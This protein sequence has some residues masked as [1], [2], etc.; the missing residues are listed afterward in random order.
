M[1]RSVNNLRVA[2]LT[3]PAIL[4]LAP[5]MFA[6]D[7]G[8]INSGETHIGLNI[9]VPSPTDT[10]WFEGNV[11][12]RVIVTAVTTSGSLDTTIYL[13]PPGGGP[14]E[15]DTYYTTG[16]YANPHGGDRLDWQLNPT[17]PF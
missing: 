15:A 3:L 12:D 9:S 17:T 4:V 13:Y 11:G 8:P 14:A 10:W 1:S 7:R 16:P 6:A 5:R 2:F